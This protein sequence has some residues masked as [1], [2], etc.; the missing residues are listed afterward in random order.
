M[1]DVAIIPFNALPQLGNLFAK[2]PSA[3]G[4][5]AW[6]HTIAETAMEPGEQA[7]LA[8]ARDDCGVIRA[9]LPLV[10]AADESLR[11]LAAP[12]TTLFAPAMP[13]PSW[14]RL[15]G[16]RARQFVIR[17]LRLEALD[18]ENP[19]TRAFVEGLGQSGLI[20]ARYLHFLN[21]FEPVSS[22][23]AYW[24]A[25]PTR[26]RSTVR[27]RL[28][29]SG[30]KA[31]F[32]MARQGTALDAA[33]AVYEEVY[34]KSWKKPEPHPHF[35]PNMVRA[36]SREHSVCLGWLA[37]GDT[38]AAAQIWLLHDRK[39]TIFKLAHS[40]ESAAHSPGSVLTHWMAASLCGQGMI[41]EIDFGRGDAPYKRDWLSRARPRYGIIVGNP[42]SRGGLRTIASEVWPTRI[43]SLIKGA[44]ALRRPGATPAETR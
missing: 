26:L 24:R 33:L 32:E 19:G 36:L 2:P 13:D 44:L 35:M 9:A 12:Y 17:S 39:A 40:Q 7:V 3:E 30:G 25:R 21:R 20:H 5:L 31:Q 37:F 4:G 15:L 43:S 11:A 6:F 38:P 41:D 8:V 27:R 29:Q 1:P 42:A 18:L 16:A 10:R 28:A 34:R 14:A 23:E 22:F